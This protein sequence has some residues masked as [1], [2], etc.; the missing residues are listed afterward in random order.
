MKFLWPHP[1][2]CV[3]DLREGGRK[4]N[5]CQ[6][7]SQTGDK[8]IVQVIISVGSFPVKL[9]ILNSSVFLASRGFQPFFLSDPTVLFPYERQ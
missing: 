1:P 7:T 2:G 6:T 4:V 3:C 9:Y 5:L 8:T